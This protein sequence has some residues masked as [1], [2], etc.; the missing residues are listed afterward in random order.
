MKISELGEFGLIEMIAG[1]VGRARE[2]VVLGVGDDA[3][4][5]QPSP[6]HQI[7]TTTDMLVEGVHFQRE[8]TPPRDLGFK[9]LAVNISDLAAMGAAPI[10]AFVS[11][12]LPPGT[13]VEDVD[14]FY[15][16]LLD[17][18]GPDMQISGGDTVSSPPGW[19]ISV[20][21]IGQVPAGK[22]L[23]RD[24]ARPGDT[25]FLSGPLGDSAAGLAL[26]L[27]KSVIMNGPTAEFLIHSHNHPQPQTALG[28][29][30]SA[31]GL[32]SC[33]IDISDGF[34]QD[35]GHICE[36]S[37]VGAKIE[38]ELLPISPQMTEAARWSGVDPFCWP[39]TGGEDYSLIFTISRDN[40]KSLEKL[41]TNEGITGVCRVGEIVKGEGIE[42]LRE[43]K[44]YTLPD[45]GGYDHF[46]H[47]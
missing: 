6:G 8:H 3:S 15:S 46:R 43:A 32:S 44:R 29:A 19:I 47:E 16:G 45:E 10:Q 38:M 1:R 41:V 17:A 27:D 12:G 23:R 9:A 5:L 18:A 4:L 26:I 24:A 22:A 35:L 28:R 33:A 30:L 42:L 20:T 7:V 37:Q 34:L 14:L 39:L 13:K 31:S 40:A 25:V 11:I 21:A 36:S 2:P